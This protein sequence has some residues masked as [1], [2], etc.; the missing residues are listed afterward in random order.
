VEWNVGEVAGHL[1]AFCGGNRLVP[2]QVRATPT[3][4]EQ[5]QTRLAAAGVEL[6]WP[7][8]AGY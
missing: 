2:R 8:V 5:F 7:V 3:L 1:A 4:L 6:A